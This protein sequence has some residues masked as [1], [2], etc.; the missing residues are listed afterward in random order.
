MRRAAQRRRPLVMLGLA[1]AAVLIPAS[2]APAAQVFSQFD[3]LTTHI[4]QISRDEGRV[5]RRPAHVRLRITEPSRE[6]TDREIRDLKSEVPDPLND[7]CPA[8]VEDTR[9]GTKV[10][11]SECAVTEM[12]AALERRISRFLMQTPD[13]GFGE[14]SAHIALRRDDNTKLQTVAPAM[15]APALLALA[16]LLFLRRVASGNPSGGGERRPN[17]HGET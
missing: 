3:A 4:Y 6:L 9:D 17:K 2:S 13:F 5:V 10:K 15:L 14:V 8:A 16:L 7:L 11:V 1:T 12:E